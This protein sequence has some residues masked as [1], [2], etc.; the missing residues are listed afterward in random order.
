MESTV[1]NAWG[2]RTSSSN[3]ISNCSSR[4]RINL[5]KIIELMP[6]FVKSPL[7]ESDFLTNSG[8]CAVII[9]ETIS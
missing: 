1:G 4:A 3:S 5:I 6:K 9:S 7:N 2:T 8:T